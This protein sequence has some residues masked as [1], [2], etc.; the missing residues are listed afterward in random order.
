MNAPEGWIG[1]TLPGAGD[2]VRGNPVIAN[3]LRYTELHIAN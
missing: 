2:C 1:S 3:V